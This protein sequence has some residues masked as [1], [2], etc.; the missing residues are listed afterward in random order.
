[1][2]PMPSNRPLLC[3]QSRR[4]ATQ[5]WTQVKN[6][7]GVNSS[8]QAQ[9][10]GIV[11]TEFHWSEL[12]QC[13]LVFFNMANRLAFINFSKVSNTVPNRQLLLHINP[14]SN[15][16]VHIVY[17]SFDALKEESV[18]GIIISHCDPTNHHHHLPG[19]ETVFLL[20]RIQE[21]WIKVNSASHT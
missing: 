17:T 19:K 11:Y 16:L 9:P 3:S 2:V 13:N 15:C 10:P 7:C 5:H 6:H 18:K 8:F 21:H 1:M 4:T 12:G 20:E 14:V